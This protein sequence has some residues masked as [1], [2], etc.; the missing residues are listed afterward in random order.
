MARCL[1]VAGPILLLAVAVGTST[2]LPALVEP[3]E[4]ILSVLGVIACAASVMAL[5]GLV[6]GAI[7]LKR[8]GRKGLFPILGTGMTGLVLVWH[9]VFVRAAPVLVT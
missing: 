4:R 5:A 3:N 2:S 1:I 6:F 9:Y 8:E 7:G